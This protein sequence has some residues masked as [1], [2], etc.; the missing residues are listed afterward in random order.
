MGIRSPIYYFR[1]ILRLFK[2]CQICGSR[3]HLWYVDVAGLR[4]P[5]TEPRNL[6]CSNCIHNIENK[7]KGYEEYFI[8]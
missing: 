8:I 1:E 4:L 5:L 2:K 3:K 7:K 6:I